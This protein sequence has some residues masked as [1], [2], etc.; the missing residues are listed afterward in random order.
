MQVS[1]AITREDV[2]TG[3]RE[4]N[5]ET[6]AEEV[7]RATI[8]SREILAQARKKKLRLDESLPEFSRVRRIFLRL[9]K[10]VHRPDLP[11]EIHEIDAKDIFNAFTVGGGKVFVFSGLFNIEYGLRGDDEL[12]TVIAHEMAHV[13]AGHTSERKAKLI[14]LGLANNSILTEGRLA[15]SFTTVQEGE[16]DRLAALYT[17]LA[18]FDPEAGA[19]IW[20]RVNKKFG[21][22]AGNLLYDHPLN[23]DRVRNVREYARLTREYYVRN[24]IHPKAESLLRSNV[25]F[26]KEDYSGLLAVGQGK[27]VLSFLDAA[28]NVVSEGRQVR[29]EAHSRQEKQRQQQNLARASYRITA[30]HLRKYGEAPVLLAEVEN[31]SGRSILKALASVEYWQGTRQLAAEEVILP[32]LSTTGKQRIRLRLRSL[33]FDRVT[34][35]AEYIQFE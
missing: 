2:I 30:V 10:V 32:S 12:A 8:A 23:D 7:R 1:E 18:G 35:S 15:A 24:R 22:Y 11:W 25:L 6:E 33:P 17:A 9:R 28:I 5:L 16:A 20:M 34:I 3:K 14:A 19:A 21:S 26:S 29:R 31:I 13:A 4:L 27:G